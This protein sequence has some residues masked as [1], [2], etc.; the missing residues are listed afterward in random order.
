[1]DEYEVRRRVEAAKKEVRCVNCVYYE[2]N[3]NALVAYA[4]CRK[5]GELSRCDDHCLEWST[6][7]WETQTKENDTP[8][9][10][11][12]SKGAEMNDKMNVRED[13]PISPKKMAE[14]L[15]R[16]YEEITQ[17]SF[18]M[19]LGKFNRLSGKKRPKT[20]YFNEVDSFLRQKDYVLINLKKEKEIIGI[21]KMSTVLDD[22]GRLP[23]LFTF[24]ANIRS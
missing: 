8:M 15:I 23:A 11:G 6:F 4:K 19:P 22:W 12:G 9:V 7:E 2:K 16:I 13:E 14:K 3:P 20:A 1:M 10:K 21:I 5:S 17:E 24:K 18:H